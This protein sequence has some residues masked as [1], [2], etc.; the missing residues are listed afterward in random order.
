MTVAELNQ[1]MAGN[2]NED[3]NESKQQVDYLA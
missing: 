1:L 3:E 2:P